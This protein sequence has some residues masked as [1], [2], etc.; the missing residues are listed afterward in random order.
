MAKERYQHQ[1]WVEAQLRTLVDLGVDLAEAERSVR[2]VLDHLPDGADPA[3]W[4]PPAELLWVNPGSEEAIADAR[5]AWY[6]S[7][8]VQ[9]RFKRLLDAELESENARG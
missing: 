2:W 3:T 1:A 8:A 9:G 7:P 4:I 6:S 5:A